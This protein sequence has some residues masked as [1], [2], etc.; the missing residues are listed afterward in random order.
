MQQPGHDGLHD[1]SA[2]RDG[3]SA[4]QFISFAVGGELYGVDIMA[5]REIKA[6][7]AVTRLPLQPD[8]VRGV[9]NLRGVVVPIFDLRCRF[10][11]G[12]TEATPTHVIIIVMIDD[13]LLGLLVDRVSDI[14]DVAAAE[15][16]PVPA[17]QAQAGSALFD[18][19][20]ARDGEMIAL[21]NLEALKGDAI[22][23]DGNA[24]AA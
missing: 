14:L 9:L 13:K 12:E 16:Q 4:Q 7:S 3:V 22:M 10:G 2:A 1:G 18:G 23:D 5:V 24:S 15:V 8:Y 17:A 21:I 11:Q 20:A 6:W 19:L